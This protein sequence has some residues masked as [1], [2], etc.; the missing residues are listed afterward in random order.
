MTN[1]L[2]TLYLLVEGDD[3]ER[4]FEKIVKPS[5][6]HRYHVE[7]IKYATDSPKIVRRLIQSFESLSADYVL[8]RDIDFTPCVCE[9]KKE[10]CKK[11]YSQLNNRKIIVVIREIESWYLAGMEQT[12]CRKYNMHTIFP[13]DSVTKERFNSYIP[14]DMSRIEFM[15]MILDDFN[16]VDGKRKNTSLRYFFNKFHI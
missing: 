10:V 5:L 14:N 12:K 13:T 3:D 16:K 1:Q 2:Q 15:Q 11:Y 9:K 7:I 8:V 4:F 6:A